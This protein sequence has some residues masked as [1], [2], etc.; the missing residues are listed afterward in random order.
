MVVMPRAQALD[1]LFGRINSTSVLIA[2]QWLEANRAR[3][4]AEWAAEGQDAG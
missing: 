1:E 3:L 2:L 4:V